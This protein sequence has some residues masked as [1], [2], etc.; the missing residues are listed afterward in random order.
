MAALLAS[1]LALFVLVSAVDAA[2]CAPEAAT[3]PA[4][5]IIAEAPADSGDTDQPD[6][7]AI[8]SHGHCHHGGVAVPQTPDAPAVTHA[9]ANLDALPLADGLPSRMPAGPDRPPRG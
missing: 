5:Q 4:S 2:T 8:C 6:Q 9:G 7:H 3:A 1:F